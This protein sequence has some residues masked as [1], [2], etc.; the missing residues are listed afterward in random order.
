ME[1]KSS[2]H[3]RRPNPENSCFFPD[4]RGFPVPADENEH[5]ICILQVKIHIEKKKGPFF[6]CSYSKIQK[7]SVGIGLFIKSI[8]FLFI[9]FD[10]LFNA[11]F[12]NA[13]CFVGRI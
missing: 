7:K 4:Y 1:S 8:Y 12:K 2:V 10:V 13:I 6:I 5:L 11:D 9:L 3:F